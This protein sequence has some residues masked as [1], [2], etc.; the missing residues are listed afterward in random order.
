MTATIQDLATLAMRLINGEIT[1][2]EF[3]ESCSLNIYKGG[4]SYDEGLYEPLDL[5]ELPE[6]LS[7]GDYLEADFDDEYDTTYYDVPM[8]VLD[9]SIGVRLILAEMQ[10]SYGNRRNQCYF[11]KLA[12]KTLDWEQIE[13]LS[14][15]GE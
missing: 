8:Y 13:E 4:Y 10:D 15:R 12:F 3:E 6:L 7:Q 1:I 9:L 2:K 5:S 11:Q 14:T